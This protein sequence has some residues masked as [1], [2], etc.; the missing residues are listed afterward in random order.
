MKLF[1]ECDQSKKD[2]MII[3]FDFCKALDTVEWE[4][5]FYALELFGFGDK[6]RD[7]VHV[8]YRDPQICASNNGYWSEFF[9]PTRATRQGCCF[10]PGIFNLVVELL[11]IGIRQNKNIRGIMLNGAHVKSGQYADDLWAALEATQQNVNNILVEINKFGDTT[12]LRIN[13]DKCAILRIGPWKYSEAKFYTLKR[14]F[15][16]PG[17]VKI[18]GIYIYPEKSIM[19]QENFQKLLDKAKDVFEAW[20]YRQLTPIGKIRV[21]NDLVNTLFIHKLLALPTPSKVFFNNYRKL[22]MDFIWDGKK[23]RI[24]YDKLVQDHANFG[25]KLVDLETKNIALKAA[26]PVRWK[27]REDSEMQWFYHNLPIKSK[28][29]WECNLDSKDIKKMLAY[30]TCSMAMSILEAWAIYHFKPNLDSIEDVLFSKMTGNSLIRRKNA[31]CFDLYLYSKGYDKIIDIYDVVQRKF[32]RP[33]EIGITDPNEIL[34]YLGWIAAV[35]KFWKVMLRQEDMNQAYDYVSK[36]YKLDNKYISKVIYW[37]LIERLIPVQ[38]MYKVLWERELS[39]TIPDDTWDNLLITFFQSVKPTKLR[40]FQYRLLT[41]RLTMN[42]LRAR[43]DP[44]ISPMCTFCKEHC[45]TSIHLLYECRWT[46]PLW[47][48]LQRIMN[49]FYQNNINITLSLIILNNVNGKDKQILNM[50][51]IIMKQYIYSQKCFDEKP[52]FQEYMNKLANWYFIDKC[53]A[54]MLQKETKCDKKWKNMF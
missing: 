3:S 28:E 37:E 14:L 2:G 32:Y 18:L 22:V 5:I 46:R 16:S 45:E 30:N 49:H 13:S 9:K 35:P 11:G 47:D 19:H 4:A 52:N 31:P 51:I 12:G 24:S 42:T 23:V 33:E 50:L 6:Y 7:M 41:K 29:L 20:Q 34:K 27:N 38:N 43:W 36:V 8:L 54:A 1:R 39:M 10:S 44:D 48:K 25:L 17:P 15:W 21:V 53:H 26:W 40:Y